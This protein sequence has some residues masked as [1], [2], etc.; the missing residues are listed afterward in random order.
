MIGKN[1]GGQCAWNTRS[2]H[3]KRAREQYV[4]EAHRRVYRE[5]YN[6]GPAF[7]EYAAAI[8]LDFAKKEHGPGRRAVG[9]RRYGRRPPSGCIMLCGA[10]D[11]TGQLRLFLVELDCRRSGIGLRADQGTLRPGKAGG[12]RRLILWTA[13]PLEDAVRI[14]GRMGFVTTETSANTGV[15]P[16]RRAVTE[17]KMELEL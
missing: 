17:V 11:D 13:G 3:I 12:Y 6:W 2:G 9:R 5:E 15:E 10:G 7:S 8:A 1:E 4:A 16:L 14:Y